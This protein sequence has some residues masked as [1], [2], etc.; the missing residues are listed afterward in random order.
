M[1]ATLLNHAGTQRK[2]LN[3]QI[4]RLDNILDGLADALNESVA[5]AV[6]TA[7]AEVMT[8]AIETAVKEALA[9][10]AAR[11]PVAVV[12][13]P[14]RTIRD[15][16]RELGSAIRA[17][18]TSAGTY[19]SHSWTRCVAAVKARTMQVWAATKT[20]ARTCVEY[21]Q[22]ATTA[23]AVGG[24]AATASYWGGPEIAAAVAGIGAAVLTAAGIAAWPLIKAVFGK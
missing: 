21:Y 16:L 10:Q 3:D 18:V 14:T 1:T 22:V 13:P 19:L 15:V 9:T 8:T 12:T 23:V 4:N 11:T 2:S 24:I 20:V 5:A 6:K 17:A 7:V